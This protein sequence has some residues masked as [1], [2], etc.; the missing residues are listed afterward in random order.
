MVSKLVRFVENILLNPAYPC[1][2][3]NQDPAVKI[4]VRFHYEKQLTIFFANFQ[5]S[6]HSQLDNRPHLWLFV[7]EIFKLTLGG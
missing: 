1:S 6:L 3:S 2:R 7:L 5:K 4:Q